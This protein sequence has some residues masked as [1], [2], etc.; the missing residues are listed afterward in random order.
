MLKS[1][2]ESVWVIS[3]FICLFLYI[4][5]LNI[6]DKLFFYLEAFVGDCLFFCKYTVS[7]ILI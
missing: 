3:N 4:V 7:R 6:F 1:Q 5:N 2:E